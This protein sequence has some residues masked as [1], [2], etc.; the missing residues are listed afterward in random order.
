MKILTQDCE[1]LDSITC[2]C[3]DNWYQKSFGEYPKLS[4]ILF[5]I[6]SD[7]YKLNWVGVFLVAVLNTK[8]FESEFFKTNKSLM[9]ENGKMFFSYEE[10]IKALVQYLAVL[11]GSPCVKNLSP[12][13]FILPST[14][15]LQG[16]PLMG[17]YWH[18]EEIALDPKLFSRYV[19]EIAT[20]CQFPFEGFLAESAEKKTPFV[21][22]PVLGKFQLSNFHLAFFAIL[23]FI[24]FEFVIYL[25]V[26]YL[27][28]IN[29]V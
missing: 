2:L 6:E 13:Q 20:H 17:A 10:S 11:A 1:K 15:T 23:I 9:A 21:A 7:K 27:I 8:N 14:S 5:K 24:F 22:L 26:G 4:S 25:Y 12:S 16:T 18:F 3:V 28:N 29:G 19:G